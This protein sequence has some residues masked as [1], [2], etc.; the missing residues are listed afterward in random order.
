[1][2]SSSLSFAL[3]RSLARWR[4][5]LLASMMIGPGQT[6]HCQ[7]RVFTL[8][9]AKRSFLKNGEIRDAGEGYRKWEIIIIIEKQ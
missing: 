8:L 2:A 3:C 6:G 7:A 9:Q 5:L 4:A 1:M